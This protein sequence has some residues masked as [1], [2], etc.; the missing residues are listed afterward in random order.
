MRAVVGRGEGRS[1]PT[2]AQCG[3]HTELNRPTT[4]LVVCP[5]CVL[6]GARDDGDVVLA[7]R[8]DHGWFHELKGTLNDGALEEGEVACFILHQGGD[9]RVGGGEEVLQELFAPVENL[10]TGF[11]G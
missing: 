3:F 9:G 6:G 10:E 4:D 2:V 8:E 11:V 5:C 1:A 7:G